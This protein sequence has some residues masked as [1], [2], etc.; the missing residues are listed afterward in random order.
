MFMKTNQP[1][2]HTSKIELT[3]VSSNGIW[4][5]IADEE[6]FLPFKYFPW[7]ENASIRELSR[8][9]FP[10]PGHLYWPGLDIDIAIES[11]RH[12]ERYPLVSRM[13]RTKPIRPTRSKRRTGSK[14]ISTA[15]SG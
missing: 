8:V 5:L 10:G 4:L 12:P 11:V 1:G 13:Q 2:R 3:N 15:R 14:R 6:L 9:E 7:F